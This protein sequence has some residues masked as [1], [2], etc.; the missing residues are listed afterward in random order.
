MDLQTFFR[1]IK[2]DI[3]LVK[4]EMVKIVLTLIFT[5]IIKIQIYNTYIRQK[6]VNLVCCILYLPWPK[7]GQFVS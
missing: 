3:Y 1:T 5:M 4:A 7:V 2:V 6:K